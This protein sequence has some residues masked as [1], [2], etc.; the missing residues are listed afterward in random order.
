MMAEAQSQ[1]KQEEDTGSNFV[2]LIKQSKKGLSEWSDN[3]KKKQE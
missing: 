1:F 2:D 3:P